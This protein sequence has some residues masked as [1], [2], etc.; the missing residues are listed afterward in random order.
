[1]DR[2]LEASVGLAE[3]IVNVDL[4]EL[5][6]PEAAFEI[7]TDAVPTDATALA[8]ICALAV[9]AFATVVGVTGAPFQ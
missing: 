5:V 4:F 9:V 1:M 2:A 7:E 3:V 6:P 8:G